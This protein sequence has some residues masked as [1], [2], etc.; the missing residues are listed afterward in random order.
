MTNCRFR[1]SI[2]SEWT[3]EIAPVYAEL[4]AEP[5]EEYEEDQ[6]DEN[7]VATTED[8]GGANELSDDALDDILVRI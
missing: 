2:T 5:D 1:C 6:Y 8:D 4:D 3:Q 7:T